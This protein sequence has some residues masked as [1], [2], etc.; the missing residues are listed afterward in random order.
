MPAY[1]NP[2]VCVKRASN[3]GVFFIVL[4]HGPR[5]ESRSG[6]SARQDGGK[7]VCCVVGYC[8]EQR[9]GRWRKVERGAS[10]SDDARHRALVGREEQYNS[11]TRNGFGRIAI[12]RR[13]V[14]LYLIEQ[15]NRGCGFWLSL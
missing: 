8:D 11:G 13:I 1:F 3:E 9:V 5:R 7:W 14:V 2:V 4:L 6:S 10:R 15:V 12:S